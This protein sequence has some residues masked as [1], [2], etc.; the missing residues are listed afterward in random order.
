MS[1]EIIPA[2]PVIR[3]VVAGPWQSQCLSAQVYHRPETE[4]M[5]FSINTTWEQVPRTQW[6]L[7]S[8][9]PSSKVQP[10]WKGP[11]QNYT[12]IPASGSQLHQW[13]WAR[14]PQTTNP[15]QNSPHGRYT[16]DEL[17]RLI[18]QLRWKNYFNWLQAQNPTLQLRA[19]S[20]I[21]KTVKNY[22][23]C[24]WL[25]CLPDKNIYTYIHWIFTFSG[26]A[27]VAQTVN[28][29]ENLWCKIIQ[30]LHPQWKWQIK[31]PECFFFFFKLMT[32][33]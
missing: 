19:G 21:P 25:D 26:T 1:L 8:S 32:K 16:V 14:E 12:S 2:D 3:G 10:L 11:R 29:E 7:G 4:A 31:K 5:N 9:E 22:F 17:F 28:Q 18:W 15:P 24:S 27:S 13:L 6:D 33:Q 30:H 20:T 23:P